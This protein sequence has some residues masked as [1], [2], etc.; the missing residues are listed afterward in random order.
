MSRILAIFGATGIQGGSLI[1]HVLNDPLLSQQYVLRGITRDTSSDR[2]QTLKSKG[3]EVV[4][5]DGTNRSS[6]SPALKGAQT[7]F[8]T[9]PPFLGPDSFGP[10]ALE[11]EYQYGKGI[12]DVAVAEGAEYIIYSTLPSPNAISGGKYGRIAA[13]D[14]KAKVEEYIRGLPIKSSFV[15][16]GSYM[17][18]FQTSR[19]LPLTKEVGSDGS[20]TWVMARH[21][22]PQTKM[23]LVDAVRDTGKFVGAILADPEKYE[24]KKFCAAERQYSQEEICA[25]MTRASGKNVV[26][27]QVS[28]EE[29]NKIA[30]FGGGMF[31]EYYSYLE[32]FGYFGPEESN[33]VAWAAENARGK[34]GTLE[35]F[36]EREKVVLE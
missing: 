22:S 36:F 23:P 34:V 4:A 28:S 20:E 33:L 31:V 11:A 19:F 12:V 17:Q 29:F 10:N 9:H 24:G 7:V 35:E 32:E 5:G 6:L 25:T 16:L 27:K 14:A 13:F 26:Y 2:A 1:D 21:V 15:A 18:N 3:V 8:I 30:P